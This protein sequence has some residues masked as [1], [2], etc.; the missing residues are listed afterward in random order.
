MLRSLKELERYKVAATDGE[1]GSV[2]N[3]LLDDER[4]AIR[5]LVVQ[6]G[7]FFGE[8]CVLISPTSFRDVDWATQTFHLALTKDKIKNSPGVDTDQPVSRQHERDYYRYYGYPYYWGFGGAAGMGFDPALSWPASEPAP[9][10]IGPDSG[11]SHLRSANEV[12]E[13]ELRLHGYYGLPGYWGEAT[14]AAAPHHDAGRHPH[15]G[16][17]ESVFP[18]K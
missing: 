6:T 4:W 1:V 12:R 8:R 16:A 11:D 15:R 14:K 7:G 9:G 5:Y 2:V 18:E 17:T 3:F 13:Y 10:Q